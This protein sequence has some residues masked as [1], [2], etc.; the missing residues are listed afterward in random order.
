MPIFSCMLSMFIQ[1][2]HLPPRISG[3]NSEKK[4]C[5]CAMALIAYYRKECFERGL[6]SICLQIN[7]GASIIDYYDFYIFQVGL[8]GANDRLQA[9]H[10]AI[11]KMTTSN[12]IKVKIIKKPLFW[13]EAKNQVSSF[14]SWS[15]NL[16][17]QKNCFYFRLTVQSVFDAELG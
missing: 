14:S 12:Q 16:L 15:F 5:K 1:S 10:T 3:S 7:Q 6:E 17:K 11:A 9:E 13:R 2:D 4:L 8:S